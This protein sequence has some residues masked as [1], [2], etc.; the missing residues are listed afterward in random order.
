VHDDVIADDI[1]AS[2]TTSDRPPSPSLPLVIETRSSQ[3]ATV[4]ISISIINVNVNVNVDVTPPCR[5]GGSI[6][7]HRRPFRLRLL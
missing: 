7:R 3:A 1:V 4:E 5:A 2:P 6:L